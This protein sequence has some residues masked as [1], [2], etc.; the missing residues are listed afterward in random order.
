MF[1]LLIRDKGEI[2]TIVW[3]E[4]NYLPLLCAIAASGSPHSPSSVVGY[5]AEFAQWFLIA[6]VVLA[7]IQMVSKRFY[8]K[9]EDYSNSQ[10]PP[11]KPEA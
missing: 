11:V 7:L 10:R 6:V 8:R 1:D 4:I 9:R 5:S 2:G 3:A